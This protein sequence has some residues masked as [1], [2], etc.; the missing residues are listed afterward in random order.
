ML[1]NPAATDDSKVAT[2]TSAQHDDGHAQHD[3]QRTDKAQPQHC[4]SVAEPRQESRRH[5]LMKLKR[6]ASGRRRDPRNPN[7]ENAR[8]DTSELSRRYGFIRRTVEPPFGTKAP[9][10]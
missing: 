7:R 1:F 4:V 8:R 3:N 9:E 10:L 5:N 6:T 2:G